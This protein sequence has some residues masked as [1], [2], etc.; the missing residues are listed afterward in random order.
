VQ[1]IVCPV[2]AVRI[3][4]RDA[5]GVVRVRRHGQI[6]AIDPRVIPCRRRDCAGLVEI[7]HPGAPMG[8]WP[9]PR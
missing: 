5:D 3:A 1:A 9:R 4:E 8:V 6:V 7:A 2:C